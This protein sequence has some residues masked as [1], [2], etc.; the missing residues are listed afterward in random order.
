MRLPC[1]TTLALAGVSTAHFILLWPPTAGFDDDLEPTVPCGSFTPEVN[2]TSPEVQ[3]DRFAISIKNV[4][5]VGQWSFRGT[6][7]TKSPYDFIEIVPLVKTTG[8]G[9][10]CLDYMR[11]PSN[12]TGKD[13]VI[14]VVDNSPDGILYQVSTS[15][16]Q[17]RLLLTF[18]ECAPVKWVSGSNNTLG[19]AC[20]N[21]TDFGAT[22]TT[23]DHFKGE[24][25]GDASGSKMTS[26]SSGSAA[27]TGG[28][29]SSSSSGV[30]AIATGVGSLIGGLGL[31]AAGLA[32]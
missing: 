18:V 6:T 14:Q 1:L 9:D 13:G 25:S 27:A 21:A 24:A 4:H 8:I 22:W 10:F 30:A 19:P 26:T 16:H 15:I 17:E 20:T 7:D 29:A 31:L 2:S 32:L 5:P 12:W 3:T 28:S 11:V 23:G